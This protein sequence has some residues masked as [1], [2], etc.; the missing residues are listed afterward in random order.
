MLRLSL[1][2]QTKSV[3]KHGG[4]EMFELLQKWSV[5][6]VAVG[7]G[8]SRQ[9]SEQ[10]I[11]WLTAAG[12]VVTLVGAFLVLYKRVYNL[13]WIVAIIGGS[14]L[15]LGSG[16][17]SSIFGQPIQTPNV[18]MIIWGLVVGLLGVGSWALLRFGLRSQS[19]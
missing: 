3:V 17:N 11:S 15:L 2:K 14:L 5:V 18:P 13:G 9:G 10:G 19:V 8:L 16:Q 12:I 4:N 6:V 7:M 1:I